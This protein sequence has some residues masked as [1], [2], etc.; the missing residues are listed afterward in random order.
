M[1]TRCPGAACLPR[2][3]QCICSSPPVENA[4]QRAAE[5][6]QQR[7]VENAQ[8]RAVNAQQRC[9]SDEHEHLLRST[10][11]RCARVWTCKVISMSY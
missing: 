9:T 3:L 4:Q 1:S 11:A 5:N 7:A 2:A 6:A 10:A 8:Q